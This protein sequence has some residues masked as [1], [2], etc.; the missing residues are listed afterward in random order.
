MMESQ[1]T[2][3]NGQKLLICTLN[4][5]I[6]SLRAKVEEYEH[7]IQRLT[8]QLKQLSLINQAQQECNTDFNVQQIQTLST[9][10]MEK[11]VEC[12]QLQSNVKSKEKALA[13]M[14]ATIADLESVAS[15]QKQQLTA[16]REKHDDLEAE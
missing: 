3:L 10:L 2:Q 11:E 5:E 6:E 4:K 7:H 9:N 1:V 15:A 16:L 13:A 12:D 8:F 14:T